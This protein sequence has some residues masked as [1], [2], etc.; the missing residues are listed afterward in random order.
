MSIFDDTQSDIENKKHPKN[1]FLSFSR[2]SKISPPIFPHLVFFFL[3]D[4]LLL[5]Y[6]ASP[7][8]YPFI[9]AVIKGEAVSIGVLVRLSN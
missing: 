8:T 9:E 3:W 1:F 7:Q 4:A 2:L 6:D 5:F